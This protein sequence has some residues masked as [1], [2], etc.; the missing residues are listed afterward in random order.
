MGPLRCAALLLPLLLLAEPAHCLRRRLAAFS[1]S[2]N[3]HS[4]NYTIYHRQ[5]ELLRKVDAI[6]KANPNFMKL[7]VLS[8][9]DGDYK[10]ELKV[11]T[12]E[13]GGFSNRQQEKVHVL[14]DF[15]EHGR[16]F[17][18][19]ELGLLLLQTL[20]EGAEQAQGQAGAAAAGGGGSRGVAGVYPEEPQRGQQLQKLLEGTVIKVLPLENEGGRALVESGR[21]CERKNG[22]GVDPNRNWPVDWGKKEPDYDPH[23]EYPGTGPFSEPEVKLLSQLATEFAPKIWVNIHS[24]ME[25]MFVPWDHR[26]DVPEGAGDALAILQRIQADV[27][28]NTSCV[29]GSGGKTVGY[30]AHGTA[31]DYMWAGLHV[32]L[33]FT[34]EIYGDF[35]APFDDCF[36]MFNPLDEE[37]VQAVLQRWLRALMRLIELA[38]SHPALKDEPAWAG[39]AAATAAAEEGNNASSG[40]GGAGETPVPST[41]AQAAAAAASKAAAGGV[42]PVI[43]KP[44]ELKHQGNV[45]PTLDNK[46][47]PIIGNG[48]ATGSRSSSRSRVEGGQATSTSTAAQQDATQQRMQGTQSGKQTSS[49]SGGGASSDKAEPADGEDRVAVV[50][51]PAKSGIWVGSGGPGGALFAA[52]LAL[53]SLAGVGALAYRYGIRL[54]SYY[55]RCYCLLPLWYGRGSVGNIVSISGGSVYGGGGGGGLVHRLMGRMGGAA[56]RKSARSAVV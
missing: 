31:T 15:G 13:P 25:A 45:L 32:P 39:L 18:S 10:A 50:A 16:E 8:A 37:G 24:G 14:L 40:T 38:P 42:V 27:M 20:A 52:A 2:N 30:L 49:S 47:G 12:I 7:E 51:E 35:S 28:A 1:R 11:V 6:V 44:A 53:A 26:A 21:L 54:S 5:F 43:E 56:S 22:R 55:G 29:V 23:E 19:S 34:W 9:N 46:T 3:V 33:P 41:E 4:P 36:R 48:G 17:I